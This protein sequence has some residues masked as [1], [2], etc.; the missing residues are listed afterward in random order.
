MQQD[1]NIQ[2]KLQ[3]LENQQLPDLSN[4][5]AH[6]KQMQTMLPAANPAPA[7]SKVPKININHWAWIIT[8]AT[9]VIAGIF[10]FNKKGNEK[11][12]STT[13][14]NKAIGSNKNSVNNLIPITDT[15]TPELTITTPTVI[16][17][18]QGLLKALSDNIYQKVQVFI[19]ANNKD[20]ILTGS[21]GTSLL[22]PANS[23]GGNSRIKIVLREF[24]KT[25]DMVLN[26]LT[27]M[28]NDKQL[29]T[30]GMIEVRAFVN[31]KSI[32]L[33]PGK[34][35]RWYLP[36]GTKDMSQMQLFTGT[37]LNSGEI[38]WKAQH[39]YFSVTTTDKSIA[40][41]EN[42]YTEKNIL[43]KRKVLK[44][45]AYQTIST[46]TIKTEVKV[47]DIRNRPFKIEETKKGRIGYFIIT[48]NESIPRSTFKNLL[49]KKYGYYKIRFRNSWRGY[50]AQPTN[51]SV[52]FSHNAI[53]DTVW[54]S[55]E[56]AGKYQLPILASRNDTST[57]K[58]LQLVQSSDSIEVVDTVTNSNDQQ[59]MGGITIMDRPADEFI[60]NGFQ[61]LQNRYSINITQLGW[62]NC[63]RFSNDPRK[64]TA[65]IVK[66]N[67]TAKNYYT[68]LIFKSVRSIMDGMPIKNQVIFSDIPLGEE[69]TI[70][71]F[72]INKK[73]K[74]VL[75]KK[76]AIINNTEITGLQ[77][78]EI[79]TTRLQSSIS[80]IN[81]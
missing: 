38:N 6:W 63:D 2:N 55:K 48:E 46:Q 30:G 7:S 64:K 80:K 44:P 57:I 36:E 62:I 18:K 35:I 76:E 22:I 21:Q 3:Q 32:D 81:R 37:M 1:K 66:L 14:A 33:K 68:T 49:L 20:T 50:F 25:S 4:M 31:G 16:P 79:P 15:S 77:F 78:E 43:R 71:S 72:G 47:L 40:G 60:N 5:D 52:D 23:F 28:S 69:V 61:Q 29:I 53:G 51:D 41:L 54:I 70:V 75:A 56:E 17:V 9:V 67:D 26:H 45:A 42:D 27:T 34:S 58:S 12:I 11:A 19:I 74:T 73:G 24:Y 59:N 65:I 8:S 13:G 39:E 10:I